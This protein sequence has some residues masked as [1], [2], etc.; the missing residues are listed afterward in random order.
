MGEAEVEFGSCQP[1][2]VSYAG[3]AQ[4]GMS[5]FVTPKLSLGGS[6]VEPWHFLWGD[7][8]LSCLQMEGSLVSSVFLLPVL[9]SAGPTCWHPS[10]RGGG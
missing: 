9:A 8:H 10:Y 6:Q 1:G 3:P 2:L 7:P 4:T 5:R